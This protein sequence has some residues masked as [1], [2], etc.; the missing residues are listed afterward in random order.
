MKL[1]SGYSKIL[2]ILE[3]SPSLFSFFFSCFLLD[4]LIHSQNPSYHLYA[5]DYQVYISNLLLSIE[6]HIGTPD[7]LIYIY[8]ESLTDSSNLIYQKSNS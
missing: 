7:C 3:N 4:D 6:F 1:C 5:N 8:F 2:N